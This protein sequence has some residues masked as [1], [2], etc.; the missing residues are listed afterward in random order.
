MLEAFS[1]LYC[2]TTL[3]MHCLTQ[4]RMDFHKGRGCDISK[5]DLLSSASSMVLYLFLG[6]GNDHFVGRIATKENIC[7]HHFM[8]RLH[9][10]VGLGFCIRK[11]LTVGNRGG[12]VVNLVVAVLD[13]VGP[14]LIVDH[15]SGRLPCGYMI[16]VL[17]EEGID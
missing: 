5:F 17:L 14:V 2:S 3:L 8:V 7:N 4:W 10:N 6:R 9:F 16:R 15:L 12:N 1:L 11:E 13:N